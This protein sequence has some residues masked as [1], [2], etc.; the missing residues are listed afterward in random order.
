MKK[1][2][3]LIVLLVFVLGGCYQTSLYYWGNYS[4]TLYKYKKA[5]SDETLQDHKKSIE[6][7]IN[8]TGSYKKPVPPGIYSE[9]G[10]YLLIEGQYLEAQQYLDM[11]IQT[12][13]E[14]EKFINALLNEIP[15]NEE[16]E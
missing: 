4:N 16:K 7:I 15:E 11:E 12:Y 2:Y 8:Q 1:N 10:Y 5:P 6:K 13:P 3:F 9:Y 14:S